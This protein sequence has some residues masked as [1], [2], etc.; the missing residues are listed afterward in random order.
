MIL[1]DVMDEIAARLKAGVPLLTGRTYAWPTL[2]VT[3]PAA[4]ITYPEKISYDQTGGRGV[5]KIDDVTILVFCGRPHERQTRDLAAAFTNPDDVQSVKAA[6]DGEGY[7]SCDQV[8][9][10]EAGF[11]VYALAGTDYLGI[12]FP[13]TIYGPG[14]S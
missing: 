6:V 10:F 7:A 3:P 8:S 4:V 9:V 12:A 1:T 13:L 5:D 14:S 11:D 2:T